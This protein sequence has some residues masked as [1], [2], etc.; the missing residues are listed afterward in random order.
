MHVVDLQDAQWKGPFLPQILCTIDLRCGGWANSR[1]RIGTSWYNDIIKG[2]LKSLKCQS[3]TYQYLSYNDKSMIN[4][5]KPF[6]DMGLKLG[7]GWPWM[8]HGSFAVGSKKKLT[9]V[10]RPTSIRPIQNLTVPAFRS[11]FLSVSI[12]QYHRISKFIAADQD[13]PPNQGWPS[14]LRLPNAVQRWVFPVAVVPRG[15]ANVSL[16]GRGLRS[17]HR[18]GTACTRAKRWRNG[19][20]SQRCPPFGWVEV[21]SVDCVAVKCS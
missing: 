17:P 8:D 9:L 1:L 3:V 18:W 11:Q 14:S 21:E 13:P 20:S 2:S 4:I 12:C 16:Q 10:F 19:G 15:S 5:D 6:L 7:D